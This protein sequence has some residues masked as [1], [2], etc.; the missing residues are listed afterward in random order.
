[1]RLGQLA[2]E[3]KVPLTEI[4][5][6]LKEVDPAYPSF[7]GNSKLD[8]QARALIARRFEVVVESP[9]VLTEDHVEEVF[10]EPEQN[11]DQI[12]PE[13]TEEVEEELEPT[14]DAPE[15]PQD[16]IEEPN[17]PDTIEEP[18]EAE[19]SIETDRLLE[20][21]ESEGETGIDLSKIKIIKASK[22]ELSG[23][24][25]VGK[26]ELTEPIS[27]KTEKK[28]A[29]EKSTKTD[30]RTRNQQS[31]LNQ[32]D[33]EKKRARIKKNREAYEKRQERQKV[34]EAKAQKRVHYERKLSPTKTKQQKQKVV[35][36]RTMPRAA[37]QSTQKMSLWG[38][39]WK[40]LNT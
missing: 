16:T 13:V 37:E 3:Y 20:L 30:K 28:E 24:K 33:L 4:I 38:K 21:L 32:E 19:E 5:S 2:R 6:Y 17:E 15:Q 7:H 35:K 36:E 8:D 1:M 9:T 23:L 34:R 29:T 22:R 39:F 25:I 10:S 11:V 31:E 40:W 27:K 18:N 26:I 12:E 14:M